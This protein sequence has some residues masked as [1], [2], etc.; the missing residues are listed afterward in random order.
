[1]SGIYQNYY[2]LCLMPIWQSLSFEANIF[3]L[4]ELSPKFPAMIFFPFIDR[5]C[6]ERKVN[7]DCFFSP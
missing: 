5:K 2:F 6:N 4:N 1:M 7:K 3:P